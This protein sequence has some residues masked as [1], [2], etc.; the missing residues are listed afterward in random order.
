MKN[1]NDCDLLHFALKNGMIDINT[2]NN[3]IEMNERKKYLETHNYKVWQGKDDAW[4]TYLPDDKKGR[5]LK[6]R[7]TKKEI[8]NLIVNHYKAVEK[9]PTL[10]IVFDRWKQEKYELGE[11]C[12][13]TYDRYSNDYKRFFGGHPLS[14]R[15]IKYITEDEIEYF[16]RKSIVEYKLTAKAFAGL[17][18]I[19]RGTF[20][21]A[22][23]KG[24]TD[25]SITNFFGDLELSRKVF[26][27]NFKDKEK[28]V[29]FEQ[30]VELITEYLKGY[31][32][33]ENLAILLAF[34]TGL[35][36]GELAALKFKDIRG[37]TIHVQR[38]EIKYKAD[39]TNRTVHEVRDFP[40]SDAGNRYL[41]ITEKTCETVEKIKLLNP[42]HSDDDF[43]FMKNNKRIYATNFGKRLSY[44][45]KELNIPHK[46]MHKIRKTYGTML[47]DSNVDDS[48]V[49]NQMGHADIACTRKYYYFCNK[50]EEHKRE[51]INS[52]ISF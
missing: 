35:R 8:Q 11:I 51:Q 34:Q 20:K 27:K 9:E 22:K 32:T 38:T 4:Y 49:M 37:R 44:V 40:K 18:T 48:I 14:Q 50:D 39:E 26:Q 17:R 41:I 2:I 15:K 30:E 19:I 23:K 46:S 6:K 29:F 43:V 33:I 42:N 5:V 10:E 13:G 31:P 12:K 25:I 16:I 36:V 7:N 45:C 3:Q 24:Y 28:E 21:Y 47:L 1:I 52:A